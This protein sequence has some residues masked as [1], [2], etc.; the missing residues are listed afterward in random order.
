MRVASRHCT[1]LRSSEPIRFWVRLRPFVWPVAITNQRNKGT[2]NPKMID[3]CSCRASVL[4][5][6]DYDENSQYPRRP[7]WSRD[8][9]KLWDSVLA[10]YLNLG[11]AERE[12]F[13]SG[14]NRTTLEWN[15]LASMKETQRESEQT[16]K[17]WR[18][19]GTSSGY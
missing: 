10:P 8:L 5:N 15:W 17:R 6:Q 12:N 13:C 1:V 2:G 14:H 16:G 4:S 9:E 11:S 18:I 19:E 3:L 7:E